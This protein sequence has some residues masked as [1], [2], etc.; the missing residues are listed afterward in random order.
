M[1]KRK[2][3]IKFDLRIIRKK[4]ILMPNVFFLTENVQRFRISSKSFFY[5]KNF[6]KWEKT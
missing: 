5:A 2:E 6:I 4:M 1:S 3:N